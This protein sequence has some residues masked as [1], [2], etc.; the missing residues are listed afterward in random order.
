MCLRQ[1]LSRKE[2]VKT[3]N[4]V[5]SY[6]WRAFHC[7]LCKSEY[8]DKITIEATTYWLFE[9]SKP[10]SNYLVL[11]SVQMQGNSNVQNH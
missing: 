3:G 5:V 7:E 9:I 6:S 8:N 4:A 11:E 10:K 2:N 1:W